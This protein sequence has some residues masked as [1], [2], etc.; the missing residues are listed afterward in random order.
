[1]LSKANNGKLTIVDPLK[2]G[3]HVDMLA[4]IVG[5]GGVKK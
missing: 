3:T 5:M 2:Y 1:M 4:N